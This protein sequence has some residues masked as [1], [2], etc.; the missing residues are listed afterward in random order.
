MKS[1]QLFFFAIAITF[2]L[3]FFDNAY[4]QSIYFCEG[5]DDDGEPVNESSVF[6]IPENG[7]YLYVLVQLPY[8]VGCRK[9]DLEIYR[10]GKYDTNISIDT[11]KNWSWF[12]KQITFYKTGTFTIDVYDCNNDLLVTGEVD[13]DMD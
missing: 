7:G 6:T 11:Q 9:V 12:W 4:S 8:E 5:V 10:N 1:L 3:S 13:I 2:A